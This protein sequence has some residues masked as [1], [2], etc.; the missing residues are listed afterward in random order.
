MRYL[1]LDLGSK[2]LG[3]SISDRTGLITNAYEVIRFSENDYDSALPRLKEIVEAEQVDKIVLGLPKHMNNDFGEKAS[4]AT[5]FGKKISDFLKIEVIMQ[6]ERRTTIEAT[7][8]ML[9]AN[10][11]R[12]KRKQKIDS[13]AANIIL[14]TYLDRK[15]NEK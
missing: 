4:I 12:K 2:T 11:S 3:V 9:E 5:E 15:R 14:Q 13:L 10:V 1:G 7:N 8:Y 6:D